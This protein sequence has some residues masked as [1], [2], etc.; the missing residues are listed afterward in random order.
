[1]AETG[2]ILNHSRAL[3][4]PRGAIITYLVSRGQCP[5]PLPDTKQILVFEDRREAAQYLVD[6]FLFFIFSSAA[7]FGKTNL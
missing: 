3:S 7:A 5:E 2:E 6:F 1:M 4:W